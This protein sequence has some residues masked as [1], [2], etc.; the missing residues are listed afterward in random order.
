MRDIDKRIKAHH[1]LMA[2]G[3]VSFGVIWVLWA[4]ACLAGAIGLVY[5]VLH[6]ALKFW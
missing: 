6:F 5:V 4:C 3:I 2:K 1:S